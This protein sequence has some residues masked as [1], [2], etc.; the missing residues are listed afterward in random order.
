M[1]AV[2]AVYCMGIILSI[3]R[4]V[5]LFKTGKIEK[6]RGDTWLTCAVIV[7]KYMGIISGIARSVIPLHCF[8]FLLKLMG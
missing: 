4:S 8:S 1:C 3:V 2:I 7:V 5:I 6:E